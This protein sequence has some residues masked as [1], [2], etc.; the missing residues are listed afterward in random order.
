MAVLCFLNFKLVEIIQEFKFMS[1]VEAY[2]C[3]YMLEVFA[4]PN[5]PSARIGFRKNYY[6]LD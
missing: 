4:L 2:Q 5:K 1:K 6:K 3:I